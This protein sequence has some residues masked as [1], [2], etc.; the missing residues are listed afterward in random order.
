MPTIRHS[1]DRRTLLAY[2][3]LV[4]CSVLWFAFRQA[5]FLELRE[6]GDESTN[7]VA[8]RMLRA[9]GRLYETVFSHHG[10]LPHVLAYVA[11]RLGARTIPHFRLI[12]PLLYL[13][14]VLAAA[15]SSAWTSTCTRLAATAA[16]LLLSAS[17][18]PAWSGHMLLYQNVAGILFVVFFGLVAVPLAMGASPSRA[19]LACGGAALGLLPATAYPFGV[20]AAASLAAAS[21]GAATVRVRGR[22]APSLAWILAGVAVSAAVLLVSVRF[23]GSLEGLY[24]YHFLFN[25]HVYAHYIGFTPWAVIRPLSLP[26]TA[27]TAAN[28]PS[29]S[30]F[31]SGFVVVLWVAFAD[32]VLLA[33]A[34]RPPTH[35]SRRD[36]TV[37]VIA[38][39][40]GAAFF[41]AA[42]LALN[43]RGEV[44][45]RAGGFCFAATAVFAV[46]LAHAIVDRMR[47]I[48]DGRHAAMVVAVTVIAVAYMV[49]SSR[50]ALTPADTASLKS[51]TGYESFERAPH[52]RLV[53]A[54]TAPSDRVVL[55][56]YRPADYLFADRLP[57][58]RD[59]Y[60]LPWQAVF[61]AQEGPGRVQST[62]DDLASAA[63]KVMVFD[64]WRVWGSEPFEAYAGCEVGW[65]RAHYVECP[66]GDLEMYVRPELAAAASAALRALDL[67]DA[68]RM[69]PSI[70][71]RADRPAAND[72]PAPR[73][74]DPPPRSG[75]GGAPRGSP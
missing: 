11:A 62:C 8:A 19:H 33:L 1:G 45:F 73:S 32:V 38:S 13:L 72:A 4:A 46:L 44:S 63:P 36:R 49:G 29:D 31:V 61:Q 20:C 48:A 74:V 2:V 57:A 28:P 23:L 71:D 47:H 69:P 43:P 66:V 67:P 58:V 60:F 59:F 9:D 5:L 75:N 10:P 65:A 12:M 30:A 7:F 50:H 35:E 52:V 37:G 68:C 6:F 51:R 25:Q 64:Y 26:F 24:R 42:L 21:V 56:S 16:L 14:P 39:W 54:L 15:L 34:R 53:R 27:G 41:G 3:G 18:V 22:F 17:I 55:W 70:V 40:V